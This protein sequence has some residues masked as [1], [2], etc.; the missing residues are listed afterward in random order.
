MISP[1]IGTY[2]ILWL[3]LAISFRHMLE[4]KVLYGLKH[5]LGKYVPPSAITPQA[6]LNTNLGELICAC[7]RVAGGS[8]LE[9]HIKFPPYKLEPLFSLRDFL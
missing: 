8:M 9:S 1:K 2:S 5:T 7:L 6:P 4:K 3:D